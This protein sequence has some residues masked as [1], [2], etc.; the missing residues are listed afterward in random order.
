MLAI[1]TLAHTTLL[2]RHGSWII[3]KWDMPTLV[4]MQE[5]KK[6]NLAF[7]FQPGEGTSIKEVSRHVTDEGQ[8]LE[9]KLAR[10]CERYRNVSST[11][12]AYQILRK[13]RMA[14]R[15]VVENF[16][17]PPSPENP[18]V[19]PA[20][21]IALRHSSFNRM[22]F[23]VTASQPAFLTLS[24]PY[25]RHW[26]ASLNGQNVP[27]YRVNG[28]EQAVWIE[29]GDSTVE[30]RYRSDAACWGM[31]A[32]CLL[33]CA[34]VW[35][36]T[37]GLHPRVQVGICW[38]FALVVCGLFFWFW[39]RSLYRGENLGTRYEWT[40]QDRP[41]AGNLAYGKTTSR[42][43]HHFLYPFLYESARA[44]DGESRSGSW[45]ASANE[46]D[47]WWQVDLGRETRLGKIVVHD[48][49]DLAR[50]LRQGRTDVRSGQDMPPDV[51]SL[52]SLPVEVWV[53]SNGTDYEKV[54]T[55][56][57]DGT[58]QA[59]TFDLGGVAARYVKLQLVGTGHLALAEVEVFEKEER[60]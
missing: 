18:V 41:T 54:H 22:V 35:Y 40:P 26:S 24:F 27:I 29:G 25:S 9:P 4:Q 12:E 51:A 20:A 36:F 19:D 37:A 47:P 38:L 28:I 3:E 49:S 10:L 13:Q 1:A 17:G 33:A 6:N 30:F 56:A 32:S 52:L 5:E 23:D 31:F 55:I 34:L 60:P 15:V 39:Y 7:R 8:F 11:E 59:W 43:S 44:V 16:N 48:P 50:W 42:S 58:P 46:T 2:F 45:F 21:R 14:D 53:S 57:R